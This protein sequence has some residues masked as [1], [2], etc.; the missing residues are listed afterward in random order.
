MFPVSFCLGSFGLVSLLMLLVF[1]VLG[2][3]IIVVIAKILLFLLPAAI[4]ALVVWLISGGNEV[5]AGIAFIAIAL[6]SI[7][8]R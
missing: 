3:I 4:V 6:L 7:L 8:K 1:L 2:V 5:L